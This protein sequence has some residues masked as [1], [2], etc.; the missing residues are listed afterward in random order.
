MPTSRPPYST[1]QLT[2]DQ[3]SSYMVRSQARWASNPAAVSSEGRG[4]A[5]TCA[6]SHAHASAR[7]ASCAALKVR[8]MTEGIFHSVRAGAN[9]AP[10]AWSVS[11]VRGEGLVLNQRVHEEA[12]HRADDRRFRGV[13]PHGV[14]L[15]PPLVHG[16]EL[17]GH[18][19]KGK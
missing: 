19:V 4:S 14:E 8:S 16:Q 7:K 6:A 11:V 3:R 12:D 9:D 17:A 15:V 18:A 1:G 10:P 5:G 13:F 2:T